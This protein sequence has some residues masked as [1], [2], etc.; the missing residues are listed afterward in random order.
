MT[1]V[2]LSAPCWHLP[3]AASWMPPFLRRRKLITSSRPVAILPPAKMCPS[4]PLFIKRLMSS[5]RMIRTAT[6]LP[7]NS[8]WNS[9]S[10]SVPA[11]EPPLATDTK[12]KN[13]SPSSDPISWSIRHCIPDGIDVITTE[14]RRDD[15]LWI[16]ARRLACSTCKPITCFTA[17]WAARRR[18]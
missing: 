9:T 2:L 8:I 5:I 18:V 11:I 17:K 6:A 4:Q 10:T 3:A 1:I 16:T 12:K 13:R 15:R 14:R 7:I